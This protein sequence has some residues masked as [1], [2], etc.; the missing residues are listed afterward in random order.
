MITT[1]RLSHFLGYV[2]LLVLISSCATSPTGRSQ[3]VLFTTEELA[4]MGIDAFEEIKDKN[5]VVTNK[6][7]VDYVNCIVESIFEGNT[8][9]AVVSATG[10]D[11]EVVIFDNKMVNAFALPGQKIGIYT[12]IM[13]PR[14]ANNQHQLASVIGHEIAHV[15]ADHSN[16]RLSYQLLTQLGMRAAT[17]ALGQSSSASN[18]IILGALGL[19]TEIGI[20]LPFSRKHE[21]EAD[22]YGLR[23]MARGGFDP[24]EN[25]KL[26]ENIATA[27]KNKKPDWLSTHPS[28]ETR[29]QQL[30]DYADPHGLNLY[31][32]AQ[33]AG[34]QPDCQQPDY[35]PPGS[36]S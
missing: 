14:I 2:L 12:G 6:Q 20:L 30:K 10:N 33:E 23:L 1:K 27:K 3:L 35:E 16:E 17:Q 7:Y 29:I 19:G 31:Q 13:D 25:A 26:W 21:S 36:V 34:R 32:E 18:R 11:W 5:S 4:D 28:D 15:L 8:A 24:R 22:I 9:T